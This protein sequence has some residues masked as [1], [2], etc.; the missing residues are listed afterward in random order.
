MQ[1]RTSIWAGKTYGN[2]GIFVPEFVQ[3]HTRLTQGESDRVHDEETT[4]RY[5]PKEELET[6]IRS[7]TSPFAHHYGVVPNTMRKLTPSG[8]PSYRIALLGCRP[9]RKEEY[10]RNGWDPLIVRINGVDVNVMAYTNDQLDKLIKEGAIDITA[11]GYDELAVEDGLRASWGLPQP[12][13]SIIRI[14]GSALLDVN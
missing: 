8:E 9:E 7:D 4:G 14:H 2:R 11:C 6:R 13:K 3:Y 12:V 5:T 10:E 1:G